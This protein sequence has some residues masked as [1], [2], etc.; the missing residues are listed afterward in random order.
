MYINLLCTEIEKQ[1]SVFLINHTRRKIIYDTFCYG[2]QT[3]YNKSSTSEPYLSIDNYSR[4][5]E[6]EVLALFIDE[7]SNSCVQS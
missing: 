3:F 7:T 6:F 2:N 5:Q 4:A 1:D